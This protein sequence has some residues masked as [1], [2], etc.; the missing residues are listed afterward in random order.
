MNMA[1]QPSL[2]NETINEVLTENTAQSVLNHLE[3]L[4]SNRD[5]MLTRWIWELLQNA[6]DTSPNTETC[7]VASVAYW[8]GKEDEHGELI[9]QHNGANFSMNDIAHLIYHGS[10]KVED[11]KTLG[12][13]GSGFLATHLLSP[14]IDVSGQLE[15]GRS[16]KF[17]LKREVGSVQELSESMAQ[18]KEAFNTSLSEVSVSD[19]FTT[20]FRYPINGDAVD[21]VK[22]G[23]ARLK[24]CAPFVVVFNEEFSLIDI[25][26]PDESMSFRVTKRTPLPQDGLY[27]IIVSE[28]E[29]GNQQDRVYLLAEGK[30]TS[31]AI[32]LEPTNNGQ[33]C[34]SVDDTP[35]IFLG[36]PL[37][38]TE[39]FSFPAVINSFEFSPTPNRDGVYIGQSDKDERNI[40]NQAIMVEACE[41]LINLISF[42]ASCGWRDIHRLTNV[43]A[44]RKTYWLNPEWLSVCLKE[45]FVAQI[46]QT[47]LVLNKAGNP[48]APIKAMLPVAETAAG[49]EALWDLLDGMENVRDTLPR[50]KEVVGWWHTVRSWLDIYEKKQIDCFKEVID[51]RKL[52]SNIDAKT[53]KNKNYGKIKDLQGLL[54][55]DSSAVKW[56]DQLHNFFNKNELREA[57]R[58]YHIVL[59]QDDFLDKLYNLYC[60]Q[61]IDEEL[62]DIAEL[63]GWNIRQ[64]LRDKRLSSLTDEAGKGN[65]NNEDVIEKLIK[66]IQKRAEENPDDDFAK[67]SV[68]LFAWIVGQKNWHLLNGFPV[69]AEQGDSDTYKVINLERSEEDDVRLLAPVRAWPEDLQQ[70]SELFPRRYILSNAFFEAMSDSDIWQTLDEQY[71]LKKDVIITKKRYF[72]EFLP[73]ENL[74]DDEDHQTAELIPVTSIAFLSREDIGIMA[75]VRKSQHL[76]RIFWRFLTEWLVRYDSNGL[77]ISK[78]TCECGNEH[79]YYPADWLLPIKSDGNRWVPIGERR[80]TQATAESLASLFRG[81]G[82]DTSSLIEDSAVIKLLNAIGVARL[83]LMRELVAESPEDRTAMDDAFIDVLA[84]AEGNV[85]YLNHAR[86]FIESLKN[87]EKILDDLAEHQKRRQMVQEN[88]HLGK[89]VEK[90]VKK[91]LERKGFIVKRKPIGSDFEIEQDLIEDDKEMGIELAREDQSWII[92][93]KATR[94]QKVVR[95]TA[96]QAETAV[97]KEERFLLCV[98]PVES[99][100]FEPELDTVRD[101]M[102]FVE[103]IGDRVRPLCNDLDDLECQR[104]NITDNDSSGVQLEVKA[105]TARF[106]VASSVWENDGFPLKDLARRLSS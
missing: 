78:A 100:D 36:F 42:A 44:I 57:V 24:K 17:C 5:H 9:F 30:R 31:V 90:L 92:E 87:N 45:Q 79:H 63:L 91:S 6:R 32:P 65:W 22:K 33:I 10:T 106:R 28:N 71:F 94:G 74:T 51:G 83:E 96:K 50:R 1:G 29:N 66:M 60:D 49:V 101:N 102:R 34:L 70:F 18:A 41:L 27:E 104:S 3:A 23:I 93:V 26:S 105:G 20:K 37:I 75:R 77:Q 25:K 56:L 64:K 16:F 67:A 8:Q 14:T 7:L 59:D 62:K 81:S 76:A 103:N 61:D 43:P 72:N 21:A 84:T 68:D 35:R 82:M 85:G 86:E 46:R 12:Q 40:V 48:R 52:A 13:Y 55:E 4:E 15:D 99:G 11:K 54:R 58:E 89:R 53:H 2:N 38:G 19:D 69:F 80:A 47:P 73:D 98:V 88:Q 97:E 95:M 39:N